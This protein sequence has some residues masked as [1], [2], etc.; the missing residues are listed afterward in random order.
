MTASAFL[1]LEG[2]RRPLLGIDFS[3]EQAIAAGVG[4]RSPRKAASLKAIF[5]FL[6]KG[7]ASVPQ[8]FG[9]IDV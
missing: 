7:S 5:S 1:G 4:Q 3:S 8:Y 9:T 6:A 2:V